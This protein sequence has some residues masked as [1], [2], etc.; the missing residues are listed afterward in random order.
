[1]KATS[2]LARR[3]KAVVDRGIIDTNNRPVQTAGTWSVG[4]LTKYLAGLKEKATHRDP[5]GQGALTAAWCDEAIENIHRDDYLKEKGEL[6]FAAAHG[7]PEAQSMMA[8]AVEVVTTNIVTADT[9]WLNFFEQRSLGDTD[10]LLIVND[11]RG[12][13]ITIDTIGQDGGRE[14]VQSA[15]DSRTPVVIPGHLRGT[16][17]IEYP[18]RDFYKGMVKDLALAQFDL[19]RDKAYRQDVLAFSYI[20]VG[21]ADTRYVANFVTTGADKDRDILAHPGVVLANLPAGNLITLAGNTTSSLLRKELFDAV[22]QYVTSWGSNTVEGGTMRPIELVVSSAHQTDFLKQ[23]TLKD[24]P[25]FLVDQVFE[26]GMIM[27]YGGW[28]WVITGVN[29]LAPSHGVAYLRTDMPIGIWA[30]KPS[31]AE[32]II[33]DS[34][35][36]RSQNKGR[37]CEN[38]AESVACPRHWRKRSAAFRFRDTP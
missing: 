5:R 8:E 35:T 16:P 17:W 13:Q 32:E 37:M 29:T 1:M 24:V 31:F 12:R 9:I 3:T 20:N 2:A 34:S 4:S 30:E 22:I 10:Y 21:S 26:G 14:T 6:A 7:D 33:D 11:T 36:L 23:L 18:I 27:K 38:W 15:V 19:A 25:G 28:T